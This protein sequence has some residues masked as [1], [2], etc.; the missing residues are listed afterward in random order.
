MTGG[1]ITDVLIESWR[2]RRSGDWDEAGQG[3][4]F[5]PLGWQMRLLPTPSLSSPSFT[6]LLMPHAKPYIMSHP[7]PLMSYNAPKIQ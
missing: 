4:L 1:E 3:V 6:G 7:Q 2:V 5:I